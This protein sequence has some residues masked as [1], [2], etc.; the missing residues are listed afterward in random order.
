[1]FIVATPRRGAVIDAKYRVVRVLGRGGMGVVVEAEHLQLGMRVALKFLRH[2]TG[3]S[4]NRFLREA[5]AIA[6]LKSEHVCRIFDVG[7][8]EN[9]PYLVMEQLDGIDLRRVLRNRGRLPV[10][11]TCEY[12]I[13]ACAGLAEAHA[14][15]IIHRDLKPGNLFLTRQG[16][17]RPL[18]KL[19]DFGV[20]KLP[21]S[22]D[23]DLTGTH[24]VLGSPPY[25]SL[26]QLRA[27][28]FVDQRCDIWS[29][30]IILYELVAGRRPFVGESIADLALKIAAET[31]PRLPDGPAALDPIIA[32]CL[33]RDKERRYS[34]VGELSAALAAFVDAPVI[35]S[36]AAS[37][38][39]LLPPAPAPEPAALR[40]GPAM[41]ASAMAAHAMRNASVMTAPMRPSS[42]A[43]VQLSESTTAVS[44]G[45]VESRPARPGRRT[46]TVAVAALLACA[47][48][49]ALV[50]AMQS[51]DAPPALPPPPAAA[52][53]HAALPAT[54][55]AALR[56][57]REPAPEARPGPVLEAE[58][59]PT[60]ETTSDAPSSL[61]P[62]EPARR[63]VDTE[64]ARH[65]AVV[66]PAI[67]RHR[68]P[69]RPKPPT[70][71]K[72]PSPQAPAVPGVAD[73]SKSRI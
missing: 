28:K 13:Q 7:V 44:I 60:P 37:S 47:S 18:I 63:P 10:H 19:L 57:A 24:A 50:L 58:P 48:G 71:S 27:S 49:V 62:G 32:R 2:H 35:A 8:F 73:L 67:Q 20:A 66:K 17:G 72:P 69:L 34:D 40:P 29:L 25:M 61:T 23:T 21:H 45:V 53:E 9:A 68:P 54:E 11:E 36:R 46:P 56:A 1:M 43:Q 38:P 5:R 16:Y 65:P 51:S 15:Q 3:S 33:E 70:R 42:I 41:L 22:C 6:A 12:V 55:Q 59:A 26:E 30:G 14:L 64:R 39:V 31:T 52:T 4:A